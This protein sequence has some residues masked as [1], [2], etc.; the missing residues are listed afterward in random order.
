MY[1]FL[2]WYFA[3]AGEVPDSWYLLTPLACLYNDINNMYNALPC[4]VHRIYF[5]A[6][7]NLSV[8]TS[9]Y[10]LFEFII[11]SC[12]LCKYVIDTEKMKPCNATI[13]MFCQAKL[14][15]CMFGEIRKIREDFILSQVYI[16]Y[17]FS[18]RGNT[19]RDI[20]DILLA[21]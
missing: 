17:S 18:T 4:L 5:Y 15:I 2:L 9:P 19:L 11:N 6:R 1:I 13:C 20:S 8:F 21:P 16:D 14:I 12:D 3:E 7:T 10:E